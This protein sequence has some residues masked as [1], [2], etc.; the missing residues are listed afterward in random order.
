[1]YV[2]A[3]LSLVL[4]APYFGFHIL[5]TSSPDQSYE[6]GAPTSDHRHAD[7]DERFLQEDLLKEGS[8]D[9]SAAPGLSEIEQLL[10]K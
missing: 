6:A 8:K 5:F 9:A 3:A 10:T 4:L 1:M 7:S 2:I